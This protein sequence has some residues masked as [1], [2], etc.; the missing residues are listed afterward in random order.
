MERLKFILS[1]D[2][3]GVKGVAAAQFLYR[4]EKDILQRSLYDTFDIFCGNSTGAFIVGGIVYAG[5]SGDDLVHKLYTPENAQK[6][7]DKSIWDKALNVLQTQPKY[8]GKGKREL[9]DEYIPDDMTINDTD[10]DVMIVTYN[11]S[12]QDPHF[13]KSW[14]PYKDSPLRD[15]I[16]ASS[17]APAY[18]PSVPIN[19]RGYKQIFCDGA[20]SANN[21]T[22]CIYADALKMYPE[23]EFR[24]LSIGTGTHKPTEED[25]KKAKE[26]VG[27]GG[28]QW[29]TKGELLPMIM[30]GPE[31]AVDYR[32]KAF[33][34]ALGHSYLRINTYMDNDTMDD[35]SNE[36]IDRLRKVGDYWFEKFEDDLVQ[37]FL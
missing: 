15:I 14:V 33:S 36:N 2:G 21:P 23:C 17:A 22:D 37:F 24:I 12:R 34:E 26:S 25:H 11:V 6:I 3:G 4:L 30:S 32:C 1:V 16:D 29:M 28:I 7:M 5:M 13:F 19:V 8:D 18:Y 20:M 9:I 35:V 31:E 27:W 10:Q